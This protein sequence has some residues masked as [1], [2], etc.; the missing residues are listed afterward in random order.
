MFLTFLACQYKAL[1][2]KF[3]NWSFSNL[4]NGRILSKFYI[5]GTFQGGPQSYLRTSPKHAVF[6]RFFDILRYPVRIRTATRRSTTRWEAFQW[7]CRFA[8][9]SLQNRS[10]L[11]PKWW[12][13]TGAKRS[14][15]LYT[16][17]IKFLPL[18]D[19][20]LD[21]RSFF[22]RT[23]FRFPPYASSIPLG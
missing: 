18:D 8:I 4:K 6:L 3:G 17:Y 13:R 22:G 7:I 1:S 19:I 12:F 15:K 23:F 16:T 21:D 5:T 11:T 2:P 14:E 20:P 9:K 10:V